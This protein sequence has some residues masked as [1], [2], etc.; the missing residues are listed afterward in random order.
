M[1]NVKTAEEGNRLI[2]TY[3]EGNEPF[4]VG[5]IHCEQPT[6]MYIGNIWMGHHNKIYSKPMQKMPFW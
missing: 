5:R 3:L 6:F 1:N 2:E 4:Y